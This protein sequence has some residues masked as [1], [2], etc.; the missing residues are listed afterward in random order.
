M[1]RGAKTVAC[2][3]NA[4]MDNR[5]R[6]SRSEIQRNGREPPPMIRIRKW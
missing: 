6:R 5:G 3:R 2:Q 1:V 4:W